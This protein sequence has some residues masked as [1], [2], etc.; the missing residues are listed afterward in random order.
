M[1][2]FRGLPAGGLNIH[3]VNI[4]KAN[5]DKALGGSNFQHGRRL[6]GAAEDG[7]PKNLRWGTVHAYVPPIFW[8]SEIFL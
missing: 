7:S 4:G 6:R 1:G 3:N 5:I 2:L 8:I